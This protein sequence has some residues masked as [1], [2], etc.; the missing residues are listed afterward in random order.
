MCIRDRWLPHL[1]IP[2][3]CH[4]CAPQQQQRHFKVGLGKRKKST[5][6]ISYRAPAP[7][8]KWTWLSRLWETKLWFC[9][10]RCF[11]SIVLGNTGK[12]GTESYPALRQHFSGHALCIVFQEFF[13]L[14][15]FLASL[16]R[17]CQITSLF[18]LQRKMLG[19]SRQ[20]KTM[21]LND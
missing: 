21:S 19:S 6:R 13:R 4:A 11:C 3:D 8:Q 20:R 17:Q 5:P 10:R 9:N 16:G 7:T 2:R 1:N 15:G 12:T 18:A 14:E